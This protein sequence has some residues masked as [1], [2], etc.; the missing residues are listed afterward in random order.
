MGKELVT[1]SDVQAAWDAGKTQIVAPRD[2][3]IVT[4]AA[5]ELAE[6][7]EIVILEED[8]SEMKPPACPHVVAENAPPPDG[9]WEERQVVEEVIRRVCGRMEGV[10]DPERLKEV[11]TRL[12]ISQREGADSSP[13]PQQDARTDS[14]VFVEASQVLAHEAEA[15]AIGEKVLVTGALGGGE[16]KL[17]GAYM[18]WEQASFRRTV[19]APEIQVVLE[20]ELHLTVGGRTYT[21]RPGDMLYLAEGVKVLYST[22]SRVRLAC[23]NAL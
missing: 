16:Q 15:P 21:G 23:I 8:S 13:S 4:P 17:A 6:M 3:F 1:A 19:E 14:V 12:V 22:P 20:G 18:A 9:P 2:R 5:L 10:V 7:L 11:V